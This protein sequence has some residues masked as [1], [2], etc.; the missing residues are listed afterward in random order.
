MYLFVEYN[1]LSEK[2][3]IFYL[4]NYNGIS[5]IKWILIVLKYI[6]SRSIDKRTINSFYKSEKHFPCYFFKLPREPGTST[7]DSVLEAALLS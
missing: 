4:F 1:L 3:H 5:L 7:E 6:H 2:V